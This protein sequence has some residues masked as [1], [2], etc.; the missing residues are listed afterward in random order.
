MRKLRCRSCKNDGGDA[1]FQ[2]KFKC[3]SSKIS[4]ARF[5]HEKVSAYSS[6]ICIEDKKKTKLTSIAITI[7]STIIFS[8]QQCWWLSIFL[9]FNP[10]VYCKSSTFC[11]NFD[12]FEFGISFV[13]VPRRFEV[14]TAFVLRQ[15][16]CCCWKVVS[17]VGFAELKETADDRANIGGTIIGAPIVG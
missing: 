1:P 2:K 6:I 13:N 15:W 7:F 14:K 5:L 9:P 3:H 12:L 16:W 4:C 11:T 17:Q 8:V 10:I